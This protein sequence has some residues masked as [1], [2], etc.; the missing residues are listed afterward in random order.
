MRGN[1]TTGGIA[2]FQERD[3][4]RLVTARTKALKIYPVNLP[5]LPTPDFSLSCRW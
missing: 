2:L 4:A 1:P 5:P 3:R